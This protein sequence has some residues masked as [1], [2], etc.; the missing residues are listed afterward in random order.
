LG[1]GVAFSML[2]GALLIER[3]YGSGFRRRAEEV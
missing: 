2:A 3:P 1:F